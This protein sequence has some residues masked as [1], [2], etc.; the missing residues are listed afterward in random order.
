MDLKTLDELKKADLASWKRTVVYSFG[1][2][3]G[4]LLDRI[5]PKWKEQY[6]ERMLSTD[7]YFETTK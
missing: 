4:L 7:S 5:H 6:F 3:E 1:A 2:A